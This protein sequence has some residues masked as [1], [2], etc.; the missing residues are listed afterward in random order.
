[1][2]AARSKALLVVLAIAW[3]CP[4]QAQPASTPGEP[5]PPDRQREILREALNAFERAVDVAREDPTAAEKLYR[6]SAAGFETL[7]DAA[8][9][10]AAL[11][12]NLGNT[13][14]RLGEYGRAILHY[15]RAQRIDPTDPALQTNLQYARNRVEPYIAPTG[16]QRL[17][18]RLAIWTNYTSI[19][20]RFWLATIAGLAGWL[21]LTLWLRWRARPLLVLACL[22]IVIGLANAATV[23]WQLH[24]ESHHPQAVVVGSEHVLRVG[25]GE[26]YDAALTQPLGPGVELRILSRR[27]EWVEVELRDAKTGWLR[28]DAVERI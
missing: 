24:D 23:G 10:N 13:C 16:G 4:F 3:A 19:L 5:L 14:F 1:M 21:G 11:H 17:V 25:A 8:A 27:G 18:H 7:L 20:Q 28:A 15:R 12:Y 2:S 6:K 22:A 9:C 26:G